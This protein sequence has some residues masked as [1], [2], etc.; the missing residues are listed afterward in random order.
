[1]ILTLFSPRSNVPTAC[2]L[3]YPS[4]SS[5]FL[6][7]RACFSTYAFAYGLYLA[8]GTIAF[9]CLIVHTTWC[10]DKFGVSNITDHN[11]PELHMIIY[12]Q[13]AQ[14][15]QALIFITRSHGFFFMERPSVALF[16]AFCLA[17]LISSIIAAYGDWGFTSVRGVSGGWIG[18]TWIWHIVWF[19]P[20]DFVK[21]G[22]RAA[23]GAWNRRRGKGPGGA[24]AAEGVP[25][26]RTQSRHESVYSN[27]TSFLRR[28]QR[29]VGLGKKVSVSNA[30]LQRFSSH[31][32]ANAGAQLRQ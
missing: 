4:A 10:T 22:V 31:Q 30:D 32:A 24:H 13:V 19:F 21:F 15:S 6:N 9:F 29:S 27:R 5:A 8:A 28:A 25:M 23:V 3:A 18:I 11:D 26:T 20:L 14:I 12:L 7:E 2:A 16:L 1:M 17:Q